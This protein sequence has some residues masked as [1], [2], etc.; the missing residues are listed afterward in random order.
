MATHSSTLVWKI[1]WMVEPGRLQSMGSLSWTQ[2]KRL[3]SSSSSVLMIVPDPGMVNYINCNG[4]ILPYITIFIFLMTVFSK[5][6][7]KTLK[8]LN[9]I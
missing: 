6:N 1:P 2:L 9:I 3:S 5:Q 8:Y 7:L 4:F